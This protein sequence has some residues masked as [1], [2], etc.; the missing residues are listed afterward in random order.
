[1]TLAPYQPD[2]A[3][4]AAGT[5]AGTAAGAGAQHPNSTSSSS[6]NTPQEGVFAV[7]VREGRASPRVFALR[8]RESLLAAVAAAARHKL[9][10]SVIGE[11]ERERAAACLTD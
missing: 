4:A 2:A 5:A 1:M 3:T 9:G 11:L 7:M 10:V 6:T 8:A